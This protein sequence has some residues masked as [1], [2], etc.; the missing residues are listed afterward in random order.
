MPDFVVSSDEVAVMV[1]TVAALT[2]EAEVNAPEDEM[3]PALDGTLH[4][5]AELKLP[6]PCTAT[7][8]VLVC[9]AV[10]VFGVQDG[11]T[12]VMAGGVEP[13]P[14]LLLLDPPPQDTMSSVAKMNG[15]RLAVRP[16]FFSQNRIWLGTDCTP[17][18]SA[19]LEFFCRC[20]MLKESSNPI[21][22]LK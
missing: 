16:M 6:V 7:V 5:T 22:A 3:V 8:Q 11:A 18:K 19:V 12:D 20:F 15:T 14:P 17:V 9:P 4:V 21:A 1:A 2:D 10:I 13:L